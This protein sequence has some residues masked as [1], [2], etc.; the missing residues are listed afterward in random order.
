MPLHLWI[1]K[2]YTE[3]AFSGNP[4]SHSV[5][6]SGETCNSKVCLYLEISWLTHY[7]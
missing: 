3:S 7:S 5:E 6:N 1:L 2:L 4:L